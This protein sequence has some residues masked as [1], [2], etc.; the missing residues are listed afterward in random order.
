MDIHL[1]K[2]N[3]IKKL[4]AVKKTDDSKKIELTLKKMHEEKVRTH[5]FLKQ[6]RDSDINR[7]NKKLL[8][9]LVEISKGKHLSV[10]P[11]ASLDR[12]VLSNHQSSTASIMHS[13]RPKSLNVVMR[14]REIQ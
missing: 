7:G 10:E 1:K 11:I 4:G 5:E 14:K 9:K 6:E 3:E 12:P 13:F 8:E 2:L